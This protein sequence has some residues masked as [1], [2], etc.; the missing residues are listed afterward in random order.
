VGTSLINVLFISL[1]LFSFS[2]IADSKQ[3]ESALD[4]QL[5]LE[6]EVDATK[7]YLSDTITKSA[8]RTTILHSPVSR[9]KKIEIK[10]STDGRVES[11]LQNQPS[12]FVKSYGGRS[13]ISTVSIRG[14]NPSSSL[15][16]LNGMRLSS[17]QTGIFD[18]SQLSSDLFSSIDIIESG[19]GVL[20]GSNAMSGILNFNTLSQ[21][22]NQDAEISLGYGSYDDIYSSARGVGR[23]WSISAAMERFSGRYPFEKFGESFTRTN[24]DFNRVNLLAS[25][26][27]DS[28][29]DLS[30]WFNFGE[31]GVPGPVIFSNPERAQDRSLSFGNM[32]IHNKKF[33]FGN[34]IIDLGSSL[35][36]TEDSFSFGQ[37]FLDNTEFAN[38]NLQFRGSFISTNTLGDYSI[39]LEAG[40]DHLSGD[41]LDPEA[42]SNI[43]RAWSGAAIQQTTD[44][45]DNQLIANF[46][47]R[48]E[49]YQDIGVLSSNEV[50]MLYKINDNLSASSSIGNNFRVPAFNELYYLNYGNADLRVEKNISIPLNFYFNSYINKN[51]GFN[52]DIG[53]FFNIYEDMILA[54][55]LTPLVT[56]AR[57]ISNT[58]IYGYQIN[59]TLDYNLSGVESNITFGYLRQ[60]PEEI[61]GANR[62]ILPNMLQEKITA[63]ISATWKRLDLTTMI[64]HL[65]FRYLSN[66][67][68]ADRTLPAFTTMDLQAR[69]IFPYSSG[70]INLSLFADNLTNANYEV[71][72]HFP[73]PGR[74]IGLRLSA[75]YKNF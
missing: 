5:Q 2:N 66:R 49:W 55:P 50:G 9:P 61:S 43:N 74:L 17:P 32:L 12:L 47:S 59:S 7:Q 6:Q 57:N 33:I 39:V 69:Y 1:I 23:D 48:I 72:E 13:G 8:E 44:L 25:Y 53:G 3:P 10:H 20:Y 54:I 71:I 70:D 35:R 29:G 21:T 52:I 31:R 73:M 65:S 60:W 37:G 67:Q 16:L 24:A 15:I 46:G 51:L 41:N 42:G 19:S 40:H 38:T 28:F 56:S 34:S 63:K 30:Y 22:E 36:Y 4:K 11:L 18:I 75:N 62:F 45:I 68:D 14:G 64:N 58:E 26:D 27:I